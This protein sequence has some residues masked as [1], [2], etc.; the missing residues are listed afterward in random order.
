ML[1]KVKHVRLRQSPIDMCFCKTVDHSRVW[2]GQSLMGQWIER[3]TE[4]CTGTWLRQ[5]LKDGAWGP[6]ATTV[7]QCSIIRIGWSKW[8]RRFKSS[9]SLKKKVIIVALKKWLGV[10]N[11]FF[12]YFLPR[13][14]PLPSVIRDWGWFLSTSDCRVMRAVV[15]AVSSVYKQRNAPYTCL[16]IIVLCLGWQWDYML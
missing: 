16:Y 7:C 5:R 11:Y 3:N 12:F 6:W 15:D 8:R 14:I 2:L 9:L 1:W 13:T 4:D 10:D